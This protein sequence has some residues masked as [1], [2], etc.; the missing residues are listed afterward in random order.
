MKEYA[1]K[2]GLRYY[3]FLDVTDEIGLDYS[4]DTYDSGLHLNL[5]GAEKLSDYFGNIL[6]N[7][8]GIASR[9]DDST[10]SA[11]WEKKIKAYDREIEL[12]YERMRKGEDVK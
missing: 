4:V 8:C 5:T 9:K 1:D 7:E 2:Y 3:N 6:Q 12:Q 10:L 11:E